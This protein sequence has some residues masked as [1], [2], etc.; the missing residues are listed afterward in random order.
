MPTHAD[1]EAKQK[2]ARLLVELDHEN[3]DILV[4]TLDGAALRAYG[5]L[6]AVGVPP[7]PV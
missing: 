6:L 2:M 5:S 1:I 7:Q 4:D 3:R